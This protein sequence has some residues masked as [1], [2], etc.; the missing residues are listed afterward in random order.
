MSSDSRLAEALSGDHQR[1][2]S[3]FD[4]GRLKSRLARQG[5]RRRSFRVLALV[6]A[7]GFGL[8]VAMQSVAALLDSRATLDNSPTVSVLASMAVIGLPLMFSLAIALC[9]APDD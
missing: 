6:V 4:P 2:S 9:L 1:L 7:A 8:A 5:Y 3:R